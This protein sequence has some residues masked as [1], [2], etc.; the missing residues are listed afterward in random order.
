MLIS[1]HSEK[2][3]TSSS[4]T[5]GAVLLT[6]D[7]FTVVLNRVKLSLLTPWNT[8]FPLTLLALPRFN[9]NISNWERSKN[10]G[11]SAESIHPATAFLGWAAVTSPSATRRVGKSCLRAL[12]TSEG[13]QGAISRPFCTASLFLLLY[14]L[15]WQLWLLQLRSHSPPTLNVVFSGSV[16]VCP[17]WVLVS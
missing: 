8:M 1:C 9:G 17:S 15:A 7:I 3:Y 13:L 6:Y 14:L 11:F 12:L 4:L 10:F 2:K 5:R 16:I